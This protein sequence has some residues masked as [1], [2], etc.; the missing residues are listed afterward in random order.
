MRT[1]PDLDLATRPTGQTIVLH[2]SYDGFGPHGGFL[3]AIALR[4]AG[5][6]A[7]LPEPLS[8]QCA[9]VNRATGS[10]PIEIAT[11]VVKVSSISEVI[12]V[13]LTQ[14]DRLVM[15]SVIRTRG[16]RPGFEHVKPDLPPIPSFDELPSVE[17]LTG[18]TDQ[19]PPIL[20]RFER[21]PTT[22]SKTW[23]PT[24]PLD[25][26]DR[27]WCR[28]RPTA[29]YHDPFIDAGRVLILTDSICSI[30][31]VKPHLEALTYR[32]ISTDLHVSFHQQARTPWLLVDA[33]CPMANSG[34]SFARAQVFDSDNNLVATA[35]TN[36]VFV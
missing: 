3:A 12:S 8:I 26:V 33:I 29:T 24:E 28:F 22:W 36:L 30:A 23:P 31:A 7:D 27:S 19:F 35:A 32:G 2:P 17:A 20:N 11:R 4:S 6:A 13:N 10:L 18:E 1:P 14:A 16:R 25:P 15:S 21:R 9:F 34:A 5:L